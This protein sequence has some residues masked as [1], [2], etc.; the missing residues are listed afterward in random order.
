LYPLDH[1]YL[2]QVILLIWLGYGKEKKVSRQIWPTAPPEEAVPELVK[3]D[4]KPASAGAN[5]RG[6]KPEH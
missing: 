6:A 1:H 4:E 5:Q 3:N 2:L